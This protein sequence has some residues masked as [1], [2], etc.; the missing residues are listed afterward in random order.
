[1]NRIRT[2]AIATAMLFALPAFAQQG[3]APA[4]PFHTLPSVDDHVHVLG[5]K[6]DLT[7]EQQEKIKPI[8]AE[9]Q[10]DMQKVMDNKSL[11]HDEAE[12]RMHPILMKADKQMR[13]FLTEDQ[14]KKLDDLEQQSFGM[15]GG[16]HSATFPK[17]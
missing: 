2:L 15:H 13:G 7:A 9:M 3:Q 12:A 14:K 16:P 5:Q 17:G 1:M 4:A 8:I 11:T 10:A 6:L